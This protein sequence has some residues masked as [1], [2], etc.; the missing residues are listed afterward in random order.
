MGRV[1]QGRHYFLSYSYNDRAIAG[2]LRGKLGNFQILMGEYVEGIRRDNP[3][4]AIKRSIA[5]LYLASPTAQTSPHVSH[6]VEY[7]KIYKRNII[8]LWVQGTEREKVVPY[9]LLS[10]EYFDLREEDRYEAEIER[11]IQVLQSLTGPEERFMRYIERDDSSVMPVLR[12]NIFISYSPEST[13]DRKYLQELQKHLKHFGSRV[14]DRTRI[15]PGSRTDEEIQRAIQ[16]TK[17][18][19]FLVS[20]DFFISDDI[21]KHELRLL[22]GLAQEKEV[23]PLSVILRP[24]DAFDLSELAQFCPFNSP[25]GPIAGMGTVERDEVWTN[26]AQR[27][28]GILDGLSG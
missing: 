4:D 24:C 17:V 27:I 8:L 12:T 3:I 7:A 16:S 10:T 9:G 2:R 20:V 22:L 19:I 26:L 14:W 6:D 18:A 13:E 5:V 28:R 11:L 21:T 15:L 25:S 1:W 23:I